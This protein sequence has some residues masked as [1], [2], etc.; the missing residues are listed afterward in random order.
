MK[1]NEISKMLSVKVNDPVTGG[2]DD[3]QKYS[4]EARAGYILRSFRKTIKTLEALGMQLYEII[5]GYYRTKRDIPSNQISDVTSNGKL[6]SVYVKTKDGVQKASFCNPN[7]YMDIITETSVKY[8]PDEKNYRWSIIDGKLE[9][10]PV[11]KDT[12]SINILYKQDYPEVDIKTDVDLDIPNSLLGLLLLY[13]SQEAYADR[14]DNGK[15]ELTALSIK[16]EIELIKGSF[17]QQKTE[18]VG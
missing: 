2:G 3:G 9:I 12:D 13:A 14:S 17:E 5:P 18:D 11:L 4:A 8:A 6:I 16:T 7:N 15:Y 10:L 1:F